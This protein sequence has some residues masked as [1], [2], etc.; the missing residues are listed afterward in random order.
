MDD[1]AAARSPGV[2]DAQAAFTVHMVS[3][4]QRL[5]ALRPPERVVERVRHAV[6]D[7]LGVSISGA[8][9]PSAR[10]AQTVLAAEG[11]APA[12]RVIGTP[13]RLTARQAALAVGV[14]G[15]SQD[16][17]DMGF[18]AHPSVAVLP[19][20][21]AVADEVGADGATT[22][23]AILCGF[24]V[25]SM[26]SAACGLESYN[27]GFHSTGVFGAFG[28]AA[29]AGVLLKLDKARLEQA[30]GVAGTQ[31]AGLKASFGTMGKHLNAGN[32][33]AVGVLSA[34]LAEAGFTGATDVIEDVQ[35]FAIAHNA[36]ASDFDPTRPG[37]SFGDRF[38]VESVM[39]KLHAAC[40][41][42]HSAINGIREIKARRPFTVDEVEA[43]ELVVSDKLPD[44]C[45]I[46]E[47][48]TGVEGMF[49]IRYAASLAL[50]DRGSG[51]DAFTDEAVRDPVMI[52]ARERISVIPV[53][54]IAST[55]KPTEVTVRLKGGEVH[56]ACLDALIVAADDELGAQWARL[57]RKFRELV[58]PLLGEARSKELV[59]LVRRIDTL[60]NIR[61][62]TDATG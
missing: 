9:Q 45:G 42:T 19:A 53:D 51:P 8:R 12:A 36:K 48:T 52:A 1:A 43:V 15:H 38:A 30:M 40:G 11:G 47:P 56:T 6:L 3:E 31:A 20:V 26:V 50:M 7:W 18:G 57:E 34:R 32:C 35:G 44:V 25:M 21:F 60:G 54:R 39:F 2:S 33:A 17:D 4:M 49:S 5:A 37:A 27:R 55:G 22:I 10:I 28:A 62:L 59:G 29:G 14:A 24:E 61:E 23:K 58:V 41:G 16:Y 46:P 13:H